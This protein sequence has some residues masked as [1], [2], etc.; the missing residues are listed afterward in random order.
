MGLHRALPA[1]ARARPKRLRASTFSSITKTISSSAAAQ[2]WACSAGLGDSD[3]SKM[4]TGI[5]DSAFDGSVEIMVEAI[6]EVNSSGAV[7]PATRATASSAPVTR[8]L[9]AVGTTTVSTVR[10]RRSGA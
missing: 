4:R 8:P 7:S 3:S 2:A 10:Q 1:R 9:M 6:E 5:E